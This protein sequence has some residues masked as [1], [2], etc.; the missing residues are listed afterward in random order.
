MENLTKIELEFPLNC[1]VKILYNRLLDP[2]GLEEW[3]A[4][5]VI[6]RDNIYTFRWRNSEQKAELL[7]KKKH[8]YVRYEWLDPENKGRIFE[9]QIHRQELT[10]DVALKITEFVPKDEESE[11]LEMWSEQVQTLKKILGA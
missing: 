9:F 8:E 2:S 7:K 10:G 5:E 1:G 6:A 3:F 4:R 11:T